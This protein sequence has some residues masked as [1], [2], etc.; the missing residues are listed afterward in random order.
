MKSKHVVVYMGLGIWT[1]NNGEKWEN[2]QARTFDSEVS[3]DKFLESR[4]DIEFMIGYNQ[5]KLDTISIEEQ[6]TTDVPPVVEVPQP[7]A[8]SGIVIIK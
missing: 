1:D 2:K 4:Q 6:A 7:T 5:M 8:K 3:E